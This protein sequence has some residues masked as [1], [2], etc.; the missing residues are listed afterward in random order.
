MKKYKEVFIKISGRMRLE[1]F[2]LEYEDL[3]IIGCRCIPK[4]GRCP[5][6]GGIIPQMQ[7]EV[8]TYAIKQGLYCFKPVK[9]VVWLINLKDLIQTI[10]KEV[11]WIAKGLYN[12]Q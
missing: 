11:K 8:D 12:G 5:A 3:P 1:D 2:S 7:G 10:M 4:L 6:S 9:S